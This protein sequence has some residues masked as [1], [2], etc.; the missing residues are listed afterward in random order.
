MDSNTRTLI[1]HA[2]SVGFG[3]I[4]PDVKWEL[5]RQIM[6]A[7]PDVRREAA[8]LIELSAQLSSLVPMHTPPKSVKTALMSRIEALANEEIYSPS[9]KEQSSETHFQYLRT[10]EAEWS[11]HPLVPAIRVRQLAVD[12]QR[13][14]AVIQ[15]SVPPKTVYPPHHHTQSE[16]CYVISGDLRAGGR[17]LGAGDF[18]HADAQSDHGELY[19]EYGAEVLLVVELDDYLPEPH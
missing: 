7:A 3:T 11:K 19:T 17:I 14:F 2:I 4:D 10:T 12:T 13:K 8:H 18:L 6:A 15:M 1:D 9:V 5:R 16:E